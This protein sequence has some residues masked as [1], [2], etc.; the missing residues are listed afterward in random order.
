MKN[1]KKYNINSNKKYKIVKGLSRVLAGTLLIA[2]LTGCSINF[3][4]NKGLSNNTYSQYTQSE[5]DSHLEFN[6]NESYAESN[7]NEFYDS[8]NE[9]IVL[10]EL[11]KAIIDSD[12]K[13]NS[14]DIIEFINYVDTIK[15]DYPNSDLFNTLENFSKYKSLDKYRSTSDNIFKNGY[16]TDQYIYNIVLKNN[17]QENFSKTAIMQDSDIKQICSI[18]AETLNY[19]LKN[20]LISDYNLLSEKIFQLKIKKFEGFSNGSYD[21]KTCIMGFDINKLNSDKD[22]LKKVVEHII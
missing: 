14:S 4:K 16:I 7:D 3:K 11:S 5:I 15:V 17:E 9:K 22:L 8:L 19:C 10:D 12:I 6:D 18:I 2:N 13:L 21:S 20:N 1:L